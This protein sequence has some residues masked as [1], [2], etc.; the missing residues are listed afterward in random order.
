MTASNSGGNVMQIAMSM[1]CDT[2]ISSGKEV[3]FAKTIAARKAQPI[4]MDRNRTKVFSG[5]K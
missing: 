1:P 3:Y 2:F 5:N 4:S